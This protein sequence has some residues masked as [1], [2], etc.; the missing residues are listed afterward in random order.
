ME[1]FWNK[2]AVGGQKKNK[3]LYDQRESTQQR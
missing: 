1:I 2:V 3:K